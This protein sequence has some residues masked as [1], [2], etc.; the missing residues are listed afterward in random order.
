MF[1]SKRYFLCSA[2]SALYL[3]MNVTDIFVFLT[4]Q[5]EAFNKLIYLLQDSG[6]G[7]PVTLRVDKYGFYLYWVDQNKVCEFV[8][9]FFNKSVMD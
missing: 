8:H 7:T 5:F 3:N 2:W 1:S 6:V 4:L 9:C